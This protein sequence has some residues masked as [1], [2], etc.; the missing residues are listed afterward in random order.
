MASTS[1]PVETKVTSAT[2]FALLASVVMA[3]LNIFVADSSLLGPLP[4]VVQAL[5][6]AVIPPVMT[7]LAGYAAPHT[8][9][10]VDRTADPD[11]PQS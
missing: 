1:G 10:V 5:I 9:R 4:P 2:T 6:I 7:F 8:N 3:M 11:Y